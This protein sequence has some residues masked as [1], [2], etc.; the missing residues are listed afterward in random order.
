MTDINIPSNIYSGL[1]TNIYYKKGWFNRSGFKDEVIK[2]P[3]LIDYYLDFIDTSS[4]MSEFK[5]KN[6]GR[7]TKVLNEGDNVNCIF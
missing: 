2:N 4:R 1:Y 6:I 7:R 5:V 3:L